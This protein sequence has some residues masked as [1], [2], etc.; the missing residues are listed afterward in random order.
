M[1]LIELG[2]I[3]ILSVIIYQDFRYREIN[4][5]TLILLLV[6][7]LITNLK[8]VSC[9]D[10]LINTLFN[11]IVFVLEVIF[12][13]GYFTIKNKKITRIF[14]RYIGMGD[15]LFIIVLCV[16]FSPIVFSVFMF[17]GLF[18]TLI[19]YYF[20]Q[21][22]TTSEKN[23]PLAG[24]LSITLNLAFILKWV[25]QIDQIYTFA[26]LNNIVFHRLWN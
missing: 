20:V 4:I 10:L 24:C 15:I 2:M 11:L 18:L 23:I 1:W 16:M 26:Y 12:L 19:G 25:F 8:S 5:W 9:T 6:S 13:L 21:I 14:D 7:V 17:I 22:F 3:T